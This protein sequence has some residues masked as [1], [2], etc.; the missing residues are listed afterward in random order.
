MKELKFVDV[1]EGITEGNFQK[2][3]AKDG[4]SVKEDQSIAQIE[5]DKAVVNLPAPISGILKQVAKEGSILKIGD[6]IAYV[7][8]ADELK[9]TQGV[10]PTSAPVSQPTKQTSTPTQ[11][12]AQQAEP[13]QVVNAQQAPSPKTSSAPAE[14]M[15]TPYVRKLARDLNV[16]ISKVTGTGP[17]G[18]ILEND[19]R[20]YVNKAVPTQQKQAPK[21]SELLE[22]KHEGD[23]VRIPLSQTRKAIAKNVEISLTIPSFT[24]MDLI[25][26]TNLYN[27]VKK[28]KPN[29]EKLAVKLTFL[30]YIIKAVIEG[31]KEV[32]NLN[33]SYDADKQ[34]IIVKKYFNIGLAAEA[35]DGLKVVVIKNADK[36]N[37]IELAKEIQLLH[38]KV[39]NQTITIEE[40]RDSTFTITNIGSLGGGF[41]SVPIINGHEAGIL[42]VHL[43]RDMPIVDDGQVKIG[44]VMPFSLVID[45][46]VIDG[47]EGVRFG[48]VLIKCLEDPD[49]LEL[50]G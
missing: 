30:P 49:F 2:W 38:E 10:S 4:E 45:H 12:P 41:L 50:L 18:R 32:P 46:R 11:A 1:G 20:M 37:L 19:V 29:A 43:I 9:S 25:N 17:S 28:E 26:A 6:T 36:K 33:S 21:F 31:L 44:K 8:T 34:E 42:G 35:P 16:D 23:I 13:K 27:I 3:L 7:G 14:I 40:M 15:A 22:E 24:H 47:A 5:T 39:S 48:N